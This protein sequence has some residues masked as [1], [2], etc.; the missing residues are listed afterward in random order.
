[1][2]HLFILTFLKIIFPEYEILTPSA[3]LHFGDGINVT[4]KV[5]FPFGVF[6]IGKFSVCIQ[7]HAD[8]G[9]MG[10][11]TGVAEETLDVHVDFVTAFAEKFEP[12]N[13]G[14]K[15]TIQIQKLESHLNN[16]ILHCVIRGD[17]FD[18]FYFCDKFLISGL[19]NFN[20]GLF[21]LFLPFDL[22]RWFI[23]LKKVII[24]I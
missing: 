24:V 5:Y 20:N 14:Q 12:L 10:T 19:F 13:L 7:I 23:D 16:D 15:T 9:E 1:M 8:F 3:T 21:W 11:S 22:F 2:H 17:E 18:V 4:S 6:E